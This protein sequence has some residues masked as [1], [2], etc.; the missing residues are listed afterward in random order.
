MTEL[1]EQ[2][3]QHRA[4]KRRQ[5]GQN[6]KERTAEK[7]SQNRTAIM[8]QLEHYK[9]IGLSAKNCKDDTTRADKRQKTARK[10]Q[11]CKA[12]RTGQP[13]QGSQNGTACSG[14]PAQGCLNKTSMTGQ[15]GEDRRKLQPEQDSS[16]RT[17]RMG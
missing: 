15:K 9:I 1:P 7:D 10:G 6:K 5:A 8:I 17:A 11:A 4:A 16:N 14:L 3:R 13:E 12:A 2:D